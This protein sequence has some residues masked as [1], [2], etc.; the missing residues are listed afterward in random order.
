V[1][2]PSYTLISNKTDSSALDSNVTSFNPDG[3]SVASNNTVNK[4]N[5]EY[6]SWCWD[7][8]DTTV[9]NNDGTIESQVRSNGNFSIV[10]YTGVGTSGTLAGT[11]G[12]GLSNPPSMIILKDVSSVGDWKVLN[13]GAN[14]GSDPYYKN[15][16]NLNLSDGFSGTGNNFPWGGIAPTSTTFGVGNNSTQ[17]KTSGALSGVEYIAYCWAESP[18]QSFGSFNG[19]GTIDCGFEPAFLMMKRTDA[20][21]D[22]II[23]D[24]AR[25]PSDP[26]D[27]GL[28]PNESESE[29][30]AISYIGTISFTS[31]GF[32]AT[33]GAS[34]NGTGTY[35]YA[36]FA[37]GGGPTG[38]VGDI[39][40]LDMT[41]SESTGT[42]EVGQTVTMDPKAVNATTGYLNFDSGTG[43]VESILLSDPGFKPSPPN[44]A[45]NFVDPMTGQTW[46]EELPAGTTLS[47]KVQAVNAL[48]SSTSDWASITPVPLTTNMTTAELNA[49]Y[50]NAALLIATFDNRHKVHCGNKAEEE[51]DALITKLA[52][53]G[54]SITK[55]LDYL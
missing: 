36:A 45:L 16:L 52:E 55:I 47:T 15:T 42:W 49:A 22:W 5:D 12:H 17:T 33:G 11:V 23:V 38:V 29:Q 9:T 50:T 24:N 13:V 10:K 30:D 31:T 34:N 53:A 44:N 21:G 8:G 48:G 2:G 26:R 35:I 40:S 19:I 41:L 4:N 37:G 46:D 6:V 7:A 39:T 25:N 28:F 54:Y 3:F 14:D 27:L 43:N 51:R 18:T 20:S 1:Q 32:S